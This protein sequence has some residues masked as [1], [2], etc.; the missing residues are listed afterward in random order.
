SGQLADNTLASLTRS[1]SGF[2]LAGVRSGRDSL[3]QDL[4]GPVSPRRGLAHAWP[5]PPSVGA[6]RGMWQNG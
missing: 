5:R 1:L 3:G 2:G 4:L 6:E